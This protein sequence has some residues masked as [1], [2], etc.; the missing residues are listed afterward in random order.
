[1]RS[2]AQVCV[3]LGLVDGVCC[4]P[5][6][7]GPV[8]FGYPLEINLLLPSTYRFLINVLTNCGLICGRDSFLSTFNTVAESEGSD[9]IPHLSAPHLPPPWTGYSYARANHGCW[10]TCCG[11]VQ[12]HRRNSAFAYYQSPSLN[13][14]SSYGTMSIV[15]GYRRYPFATGIRFLAYG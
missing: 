12:S 7:S 13:V 4:R 8:L 3:V 1:M 6:V 11:T 14:V 15:L 5:A 10:W 9:H 2:G